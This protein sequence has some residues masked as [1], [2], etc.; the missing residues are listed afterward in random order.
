MKWRVFSKQESILSQLAHVVLKK[1]RGWKN[2]L[3]YT[4]ANV[5][6]KAKPPI[7]QTLVFFF[8]QLEY[9]SCYI[10]FFLWLWCF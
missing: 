9:G 4:Q 8:L 5:G 2:K 1:S 10:L 6:A 3:K 7:R